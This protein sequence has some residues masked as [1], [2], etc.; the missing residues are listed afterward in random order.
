MV[1]QNRLREW[2]LMGKTAGQL[3][4]SVFWS[5]FQPGSGLQAQKG[6]LLAEKTDSVIAVT[7]LH[8]NIRYRY[9]IYYGACY[10]QIYK[11]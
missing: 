6:I 9:P 11:L 8:R 2:D 4:A 3:S 10:I 7:L 1:Q 5:W